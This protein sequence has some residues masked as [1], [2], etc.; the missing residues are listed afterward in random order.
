M[1]TF[2]TDF[3]SLNW[4]V[5]IGMLL[6]TTFLGHQLKGKQGDLRGFFLG[7]KS[8]P[9]WAVAGSL[10]ATRTSALVFIS[11]PAA[12]Y[13]KNGNCTFMMVV[14]GAIL[15]DLIM[16]RS[17]IHKYYENEIYSPYEYI[18]LKLGN[19]TSNL[20]R[21]LWMGGTILSQSVRLLATSLVLNVIT[22]IDLFTCILIMGTFSVIWS[23]MGGIATVIWTDVIQFCV[24]FCGAIFAILY[25]LKDIPGGFGEV[26][27][28]TSSLGKTQAIDFSLDPTKTYTLWVALFAVTV[29]ELG[30]LT[31]DQMFV[32]RVL[33]CKDLNDSRKSIYYG[34]FLSN[35]TTPIML[36]VGLCLVAYYQLN[37]LPAGM[38][39]TFANEPDK[40]FPFFLVTEIPAGISGLIIASIFAAGIS[41]LDSAM[42]AVSEVCVNGFYRPYVQKEASERHYLVASKVLV[43]CWGV[44]FSLVSYGMYKFASEGLLAL[45]LSVYGYVYGTL[46]GIAILAFWRK[47][48]FRAIAIGATFSVSAVIYLRT[49]S[50]AFFWVY[51]IAT[52]IQL[53]VSLLISKADREENSVS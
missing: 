41:T 19:N 26:W 9:W 13:M 6:L 22:G 21:I 48:S 47:A 31:I 17:L 5:L 12:V 45:G 20:C 42:T 30:Q 2:N 8:M 14:L 51:P 50:L 33:C 36:C 1:E 32:Q 44:V 39:G 46:F 40:V 29:F 37:P 35:A 16:G 25:C 3:G 27:E 52:M 24:F 53:S 11:I 18:G 10:T 15:G 34:A 38:E 23:I 4:V 28:I 7:N 49:T 43:A